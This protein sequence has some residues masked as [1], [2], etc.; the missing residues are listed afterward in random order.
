MSVTISL[1]DDCVEIE[2]SGVDATLALRR[3]LSIPLRHIT[4]ARVEPVESVKRQLGWR[5]GGAYFPGRM[6]TGN[7]LSRN[8]L[9]GRQFWS[10]YR[11]A[12][13]LVLDVAAGPICRVVL[14][15]PDRVHLADQINQTRDPR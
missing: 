6:A 5:V 4:S 8:G 14:Q 9:K 10:V 3:R 1:R 15:S 13:V 12:E 2:L 11:D 7:F